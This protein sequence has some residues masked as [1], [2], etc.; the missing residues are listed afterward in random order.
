MTTTQLLNKLA[1]YH[2]LSV[3]AQLRYMQ[4]A[5]YETGRKALARHEHYERRFYDVLGALQN[6]AAYETR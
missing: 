1:R 4:Y 2:G 5:G 6:R 3:N